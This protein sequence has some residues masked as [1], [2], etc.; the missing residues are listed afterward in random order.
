MRW[1]KVREASR[2]LA[3]GA[4]QSLL[5]LLEAEAEAE[6]EEDAAVAEA[7]SA[8]SPIAETKSEIPS[9]L[10]LLDTAELADSKWCIASAAAWACESASCGGRAAAA[11]TRLRLVFVAVGVVGVVVVKF[12]LEIIVRLDRRERATGARLQ[13]LEQ[14]KTSLFCRRWRK[15]KRKSV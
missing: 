5:L 4:S 7:A 3:T 10:P 2:E 6:A 13:F 12:F 9:V 11:V 1:K 14:G 8:R 15:R